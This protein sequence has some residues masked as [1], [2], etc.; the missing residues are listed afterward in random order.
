MNPLVG[1]LRQLGKDRVDRLEAGRQVENH[2]K[3][4]LGSKKPV[5]VR[6]K[7]KDWWADFDGR[8]RPRVVFIPDPQVKE[9]V[10]IEHLAAAGEYVARKKPDVI[11]Q[12]MDWW[13]FAYRSRYDVDLAG[14]FCGD[15]LS[16][17][18]AGLHG[19]DAFHAPIRAERERCPWWDPDEHCTE[20]NHEFRL[21]RD[22]MKDRRDLRMVPMPEFVVRDEGAH[23]HNYLQVADIDGVLFSHQFVN[24]HTG[25]AMGG[26]ALNRLKTV[27]RSFVQG[28]QQ[29]FDFAMHTRPDGTRM[30]GLIAG[31]FYQHYEEYLGPQGNHHWR[32]IVVLNDLDGKGDYDV[33]EVR[34]SYLLRRFKPT[35]LKASGSYRASGFGA[36]TVAG[37]AS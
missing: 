27:G 14:Y 32:G 6:T 2:I 17:F 26:S 34:L 15:H 3:R 36:F 37:Q 21:W 20:G 10:P 24:P 18:C 7:K 4:R 1:H 35:P 31:A 25:R 5:L 28:H 12:A 19:W 11:V 30:R 29:K 13:D 16:D 9:G 22:L 23:W 33:T 8:T